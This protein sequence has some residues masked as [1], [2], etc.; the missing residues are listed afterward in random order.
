MNQGDVFHDAS[1]NRTFL[2]VQGITSSA[3]WALLYKIWHEYLG[4][5]VR[6]GELQLN[7]RVS[8]NLGVDH[9]K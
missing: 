7:F 9:N 4:G 2:L 8:N 6:H 1:F 3:W 5:T